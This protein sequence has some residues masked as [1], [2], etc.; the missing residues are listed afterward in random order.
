MS[1]HQANWFGERVQF[2]YAESVAG[3]TVVAVRLIVGWWFLHA[4]LDKLLAA[5]AFDASGWL[6][7]ATAASPIHGFL[8]WAGQTPWMLGFT[9]FMI[10]VGEV[11][12]GLGL[13]L[14]ALTRLAA[15]FGG[16]LM[17]LFYLGSADWAHG[18]VN[19]YV[20]GFLLFVLVGV[21]AAGRIF[22]LDGIIERMAAVQNN[23]WLKYLL[24]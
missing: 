6:I 15:F 2:D 23:T 21:L 13:M 8:A 9:N 16:V 1:T 18:F 14:G 10:P 17:M 11:L 24:G 5:E 20:L 22:G 3:Y 19:E 12:I 4:G 7:N